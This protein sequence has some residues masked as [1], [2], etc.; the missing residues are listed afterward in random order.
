M[1]SLYERYCLPHL[2]NLA[3]GA[4][5]IQDQRKRI[6]PLA[7]GRVAEFGIG[8]GLNLPYYNPEQVDRIWGVEPSPGMYEKARKI[9]S[10]CLIPVDWLNVSGDHTPLDN[11]CADTVVLTYTLC[12]VCHWQ[13]TLDEIRRILKPNGTLLF[14]EHGLAPDTRVALWQNRLD[15]F[16][17]RLAGGCHLN[18]PVPSCLTAAGFT[19][20]AIESCYL[21]RT[22]KILGFNYRGIARIM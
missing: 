6:I 21:L 13:A 19:I 20:D 7:Y 5:Q 14:C 11:A 8:T 18:R 16:W 15:P 1:R 9:L 2:I 4:S 3:C 17:M 22:P 10:R 12:S